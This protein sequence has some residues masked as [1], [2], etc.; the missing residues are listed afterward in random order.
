[1][2]VYGAVIT[3]WGEADQ[4]LLFWHLPILFFGIFSII[5]VLAAVDSLKEEIKNLLRGL[6]PHWLFIFDSLKELIPIYVI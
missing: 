6:L 2:Y 1:M 3:R 4:S 5:A